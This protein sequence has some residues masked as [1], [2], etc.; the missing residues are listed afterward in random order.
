MSQDTPETLEVNDLDHFVRL[1]TGWHTT[2]VNVLRHILSVPT[3][4]A[5]EINGEELVL[6]G[7][8]HKGFVAGVTV[9]LAELGSLPFVAETEDQQAETA[10]SDESIQAH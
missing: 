10:T 6:D 3:G 1:L 5:V 4:T 7:D 2:K 9:A 8:L